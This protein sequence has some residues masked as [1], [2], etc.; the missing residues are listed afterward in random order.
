M[1]SATVLY[2]I[3]FYL[4]FTSAFNFHGVQFRLHPKNYVKIEIHDWRPA[5]R[6]NKR[7]A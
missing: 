1:S 7:S 3:Y 4:I 2:V 5:L 6:K